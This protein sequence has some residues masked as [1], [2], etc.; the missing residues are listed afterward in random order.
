MVKAYSNNPVTRI[1]E[2]IG[3]LT[4]DLDLQTFVMVQI[5]INVTVPPI[6]M[7]WRIDPH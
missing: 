4:S 1:M 5:I 2:F 3:G 7:D 6:A